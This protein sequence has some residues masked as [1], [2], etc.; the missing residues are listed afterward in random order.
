MTIN[1][2]QELKDHIRDLE[3]QC[4]VLREALIDQIQ[5]ADNIDRERATNI[6]N[7]KLFHAIAKAEDRS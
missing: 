5:W 4:D 3:I 2:V 7:M 6:V 1:V